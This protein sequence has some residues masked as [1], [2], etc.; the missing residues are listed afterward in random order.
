MKRYSKVAFLLCL[1]V[2]ALL[3]LPGIIRAQNAPQQVTLDLA[4]FT[5]TPSSFTATQGQPVHFTLNNKGKFPHNVT[6]MMGSEMVTLLAQPVAGGQT[7]NADFTFDQVGAWEMHCPVDSHAQRG[8]VG[9]VIVNAA[10]AP[11]MPVTGQPQDQLPMLM[12]GL[13][14]IVVV[15]SGLVVRRLRA[16]RVR[17]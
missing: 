14:A 3:V 12:G 13:A 5:I 4:E 6:F 11:G 10:A 9:Q 16:S 1:P 7:A 15:T 17:D 8:M 2:L